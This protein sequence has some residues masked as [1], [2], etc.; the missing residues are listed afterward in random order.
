MRPPLQHRYANEISLGL[1]ETRD[2]ERQG[3]IVSEDAKPS[4]THPCELN[5]AESPRD[6]FCSERVLE[7]RRSLRAAKAPR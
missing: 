1:L 3:H 7:S 5:H 2:R 4:D 6:D